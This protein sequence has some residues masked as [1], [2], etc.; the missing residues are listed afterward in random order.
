MLL[1]LFSSLILLWMIQHWLSL[2]KHSKLPSPGVCLPV[3]G[4]FYLFLNDSARQ[5]PVSAL[6]RLWRTHQKGGILW[7]RRFA[8]DIL[9]V[10]DLK[11]AKQLFNHPDMQGR[12]NHNSALRNQLLENRGTVGK[13]VHGVLLSDGPIWAEQRRFTLRTLRDFGFGKAKMEDL[14][15]EEVEVFNE[16][17]KS[18]GGEPI[19][20]AGKLNLPILN[21]L[22]KITVGQRFDY[23]DPK[24]GIILAKLTEFFQRTANPK[25]HLMLSFPRMSKL[26]E[27]IAPNV[28]ERGKT[29]AINKEITAL[30]QRTV[31]DHEKTI[32]VNDPRD[33]TDSVLLEIQRTTDPSSS[34]YGDSGRINLANT[35]VDLFM[36]GNLSTNLH[37]DFMYL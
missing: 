23:D 9:L 13:E 11:L 32:D 37:L 2:R 27:M 34:F 31:R 16:E 6:S 24:L 1:M 17:L 3:L 30:M 22:W 28:F 36:A 14:I 29:I 12:S 10:G 21:S 8:H 18:Y 4:H 15:N 7:F 35:L 33:F 19:D 5:D 25:Q 26:L 20:I